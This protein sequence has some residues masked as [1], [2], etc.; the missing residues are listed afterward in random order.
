M[1]GTSTMMTTA[2]RGRLGLPGLMRALAGAAAG[3]ALAAMP[4][5]AQEFAH[6]IIVPQSRVIVAPDHHQPVSIQ[7]VE[8]TIDIHGQ[9]A[10][11]TLRRSSNRAVRGPLPCRPVRR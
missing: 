7:R 10:T 2:E 6:N 9:V 3:L 8:T 4:A 11:T 5:Q 1:S